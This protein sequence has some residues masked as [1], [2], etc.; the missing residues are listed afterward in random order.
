[1]D[2]IVGRIRGPARQSRATLIR[3]YGC[4]LLSVAA[5]TWLRV[6]IDPLLGERNP[7]VLMFVPVVVAAWYGGR[8]PALLAVV[9]IAVSL[10]LFF[11]MNNA[12]DWARLAVFILVASGVALLGGAMNRALDALEMDR[13]FLNA[14]VTTIPDAVWV[15]SPDGVMLACNPGFESEMRV[16]SKDI[17]GKTFYD[18]CPRD[19][20]DLAWQKD[21]EAIAA[22]HAVTYDLPAGDKLLQTIKTPMHDA[23]GTLIGVLSIAR[24]VTERERS[25]QALRESA[26]LHE[27]LENLAAGLPGTLYTY[28]IGP[29]GVTSVPYAS[30]NFEEVIGVDPGSLVD[31]ASAYGAV[32]DGLL[33]IVRTSGNGLAN[34]AVEFR[35]R[36]P[37]KGLVWLQ[38]STSPVRDEDGGISLHTYLYDVT[39][40]KKDSA[41][42]DEET[43]LRAVLMEQSRD[44]IVVLSNDGVVRD[45]NEAFARMLG[46]R[47]DEVR[48]LRVWDFD[49]KRS[50]EEVL[51]NVGSF[52][53]AGRLLERTLR[54]K[55][56]TAIEVE[57]SV[58]VA[59]RDGERLLNCVVFD[60]TEQKAARAALEESELRY[61]SVVCSMAEGV[62]LQDASGAIVFFNPSAER[63]LI[64]PAKEIA[65]KTSEDLES[66]TIRE[67]GS[68]F[69]GREHPAMLTLRT[70]K[71]SRG[72]LMGLPKPD[73]EVTW[74]SINS[75]P[76]FQP[77]AANPH[78]VV[79]T[80]SDVSEQRR[81]EQTLWETVD[82]LEGQKQRAEAATK[83]KSEFLSAMSHEIRTP[84]NGVIGMTGLLLGTPLSAEQLEYVGTIRSSGDALLSIIDDILDF[85]KIE[86]GRM[87]LERL[88]FA[89]RETLEEAVEVVVEKAH[90]KG[91]ELN[92]VVDP[93][94]E[95]SVWGD[96]GRLRQVLLN[97]L[98]NA[99]K[100]TS[101]GEVLV[102]VSLVGAAGGRLL[103]CAVTDTGIGLSSEQIERL[104]QAFTQADRST[105]RRFGG[106]GL[107]LVICQRL[108]A[109]MGGTVGVESKPG[110][111]STFWF[112]VRYEPSGMEH[113]SRLVA[114]WQGKRVLVMDG[115]ESSRQSLIGQL[116]HA[117]LDT[118]AVANVTEGLAALHAAV[119]EGVKFD[120]AVADAEMPGMEGMALVETLRREPGCGSLPM[121]LLGSSGNRAVREYAG[122]LSD[123]AFVARPA[124]FSHLL[125]AM[126]TASG[127]EI[128]PQPIERVVAPAP[129]SKGYVLVAED[130][131]TNQ[132]VARLLLERLG[133][134]VD[135][136]E[137]GR[138]AVAAVARVPYDLVFMDCQMPELDG[139]EASRAIRAAEAAT[140][141]HTPIVALTASATDCE[142]QICLAAGMDGYLSK[143][144]RAA[145]LADTVNCWIPG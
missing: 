145:Q 144:V 47:L 119:H 22:G 9:L 93:E 79:A 89:L 45:V 21:Q 108:T 130:N 68:P 128:P 134:R 106:T 105:T 127:A 88:S 78:A 4:A 116:R 34:S 114:K 135:L 36:H 83:A 56:G 102:H 95:D 70:G 1:M 66:F 37:K 103:R 62:V 81:L 59:T 98:S 31:N 65:G 73:G 136:V 131:L 42:L 126:G 39:Q 53:D 64:G 17:L 124:R 18:F 110:E 84:M 120:M 138:E 132:K 35:I 100:F 28:R 48:Q 96:P 30:A 109:L 40:Q 91:L 2:W 51:A 122:A 60:I 7:F 20:A 19:V 142:R 87:Q 141:R 49:A 125:S 139:Y 92:L 76:L 121:V 58:S 27:R 23:H 123:A 111:G 118:L 46:Y 75:E 86:A 90:R 13:A 29:D 112:T 24:D 115:R 54:R 69:P 67:D 55:D 129:G 11:L 94:V 101:A 43:A 44:G 97:Y 8:G 99:V 38:G 104:F 57:I 50:R 140:G 85:S 113:D 3:R 16:R 133:C 25:R 12:Q 117:G 143:P 14:I 82:A 32:V 15:K 6:L 71:P 77:G 52:P 10:N 72:V 33:A 107:G 26:V 5:V 61:R 63:M 74:I 80:F 41:A 137:N